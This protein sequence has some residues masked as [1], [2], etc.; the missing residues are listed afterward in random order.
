MT[1]S[2][3]HTMAYAEQ[4]VKFR[5]VARSRLESTPSFDEEIMALPLNG[6]D[7][8][9]MKDDSFAISGS[10]PIA[11]SHLFSPQYGFLALDYTPLRSTMHSV[12]PLSPGQASPDSPVTDWGQ[13]SM[14]SQATVG[15]VLQPTFC[16]PFVSDSSTQAVKA[17]IVLPVSLPPLVQLPSGMIWCPTDL[18]F[19]ALLDAADFPAEYAYTATGARRRVKFNASGTTGSTLNKQLGVRVVVNGHKVAVFKFRG[20]LLAF[21]AVCPHAGGSLELGDIEDYNGHVCV[22]CPSHGF[23]FKVLPT[24]RHLQVPVATSHRPDSGALPGATAASG[25]PGTPTRTSASQASCKSPGRS[26][27][28]EVLSSA[29]TLDWA[30]PSVSPPN[31]WTLPLFP[32][33]VHTYDGTIYIGFSGLSPSI[34]AGAEDF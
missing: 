33:A 13:G 2:F 20:S 25:P 32:A 21:D 12:G 30:G 34:F 16:F 27:A 14:L 19:S 8:P 28:L 17:T 15:E 24:T 6:S 11:N 22:C 18:K 23:L 29:T 31:M 7:P 9:K 5:H 26:L 10:S 3:V 1:M 4:V